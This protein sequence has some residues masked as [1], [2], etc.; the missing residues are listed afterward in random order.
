[1]ILSIPSIKDDDDVFKFVYF[2]F[3]PFDY[4]VLSLKLSKL[5]ASFTFH[6][7]TLRPLGS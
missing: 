3:D 5:P 6:Q 2:L 7:S 1:M 4:F